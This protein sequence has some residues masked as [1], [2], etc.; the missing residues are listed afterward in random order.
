[1]RRTMKTLT[2]NAACKRIGSR[3]ATDE[4]LAQQIAE[5]EAGGVYRNEHEILQIMRRKLLGAIPISL[6]F[7][8][9]SI[10]VKGKIRSD[11]IPR[12]AVHEWTGA[13]FGNCEIKIARYPT[14]WVYYIVPFYTIL[15]SKFVGKQ[16]VVL[17]KKWRSTSSSS[18]TTAFIGIIPSQI[19]KRIAIAEHAFSHLFLI[20]ETEPKDWTGVQTVNVDP[21]LIGTIDNRAWLF[22]KFDT[23]PVEDYVAMEFTG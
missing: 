8:S 14:P 17:S 12:F 13:G 22:D 11:I 16:R 4:D 19:K 3:K 18:W 1:M 7:L 20:A 23:T 5:I 9:Q 10:T 21:L 15:W 6:D 2:L